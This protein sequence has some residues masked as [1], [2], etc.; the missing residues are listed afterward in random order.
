MNRTNTQDEDRVFCENVDVLKIRPYGHGRF[1]RCQDSGQMFAKLFTQALFCIGENVMRKFI[2]VIYEVE[3]LEDV[4]II[5]EN[6]EQW[7]WSV[8]QK[9]TP[10]SVRFLHK[11]GEQ[12]LLDKI[13]KDGLTGHFP[14]IGLRSDLTI[15]PL[16]DIEIQSALSVAHIKGGKVTLS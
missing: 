6:Y 15:G 8:G 13:L 16:N 4:S 9:D 12:T 10:I 11:R 14:L 3:E 5:S 2:S 1:I 7:R